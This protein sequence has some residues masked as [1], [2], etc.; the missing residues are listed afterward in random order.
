MPHPIIDIIKEREKEFF[1][2]ITVRSYSHLK[3]D[4]SNTAY[5]LVSLVE[6][7]KIHRATILAV[8]T[9]LDREVDSEHRIGITETDWMAGYNSA[10]TLVRSKLLEAIKELGE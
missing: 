10:L 5:P 8:L 2:E 6:A 3:G 7:R 1:D 4:P 9:E